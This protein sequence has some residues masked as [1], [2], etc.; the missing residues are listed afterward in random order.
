MEKKCPDCQVVMVPGKRLDKRGRDSPVD[1]SWI[2][3]D[4]QRGTWDTF[5]GVDPSHKVVTY[6]CPKCGLLRSY[7]REKMMN[8]KTRE[9][10][11]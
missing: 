11:A 3:D 4:Y 8:K 2:S 9:K 1:E 7:L 5:F 6:A 10:S